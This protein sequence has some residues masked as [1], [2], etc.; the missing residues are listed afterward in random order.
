MRPCLVLLL[1]MM[2]V[3][4]S[5]VAQDVDAP[6]RV[7]NASM[8]VVNAALGGFTAGLSRV[9]TGKPFWTAF[10]RGAAAGTVVFAG[11]RII[12]EGTSPGWWFGRQLAA[13][14]SSEVANAALGRPL[15]QTAVLPVGPIRIH[16][17]R[18]ARRKVSPRLDLV[19]SIAAVVLASRP[20]SRFA[21][22]ESLSTGATVFLVRE[23]SNEVGRSTAGVVTVSELVPDGSFPP[24]KGKRTVLSHEMV[25]AAQYDFGFAAWGDAMQAAIARRNSAGRVISGFVDINLAFPLQLGA[26]GIIDYEDRPWEREAVSLAGNAR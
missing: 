7:S 22:R 16:L 5:A 1:A 10:G 6:Q 4:A 11:K 17:D 3:S 13:I 21:I 9:A 18:S 19:S 15:L 26:N 24:L 8:L 25:H 23:T 14:G 12:G 20:G 2:L